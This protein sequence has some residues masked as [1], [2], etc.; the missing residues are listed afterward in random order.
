ML[1]ATSRPIPQP[2]PWTTERMS[3]APWSG[4]KDRD[5]A[6]DKAHND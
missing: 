1:C 4:A 3:P 2:N 6:S 5:R